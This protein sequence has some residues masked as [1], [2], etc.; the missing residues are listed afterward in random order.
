MEWH[1]DLPRGTDP[2]TR[3]QVQGLYRDIENARSLIQDLS[4]KIDAL[5]NALARE[6]RYEV[7]KVYVFA[8]AF[9]AALAA[10]YLVKYYL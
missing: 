7:G 10:G 1:E 8:P 2:A 3:D 4:R 9:V 5:E 6:M